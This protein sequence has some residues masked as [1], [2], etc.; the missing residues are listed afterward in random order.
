MRKLEIREFENDSLLIRRKNQIYLLNLRVLSESTIPYQSA[1]YSNYSIL[2]N[3]QFIR[4]GLVDHRVANDLNLGIE[5]PHILKSFRFYDHC[6]IEFEEWKDGQCLSYKQ[7]KLGDIAERWPGS[8][9]YGGYGKEWP[10]SF[11]AHFIK[12]GQRAETA[13]IVG[14]DF[15][16]LCRLFP[17]IA[18]KISELDA[19]RMNLSLNSFYGI[20]QPSDYSLK[21][22]S[23]EVTNSMTYKWGH[24]PEEEIVSDC[25]SLDG[26]TTYVSTRTMGVWQYDNE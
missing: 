9:A 1:L 23:N 21:G 8:S 7:I 25:L 3:G 6:K 11:P 20:F 2:V 22:F 19:N 14:E 15:I 24:I 16:I 13:N 5:I 12:P 17:Y 18:R 10:V 26:L 4:S